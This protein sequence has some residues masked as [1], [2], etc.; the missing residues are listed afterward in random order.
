MAPGMNHIAGRAVDAER[1]G[2]LHGLRQDNLDL[3]AVQTTIK[4]RHVGNCGALNCAID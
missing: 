3:G 4:P 1:S 2:E